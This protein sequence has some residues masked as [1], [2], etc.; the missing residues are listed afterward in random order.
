[1]PTD[2]P[3]RR[4]RYLGLFPATWN[5]IREKKSRQSEENNRESERPLNG[6]VIHLAMVPLAV[7]FLST[8]MRGDTIS[9]ESL[10]RTLL[11]GAE[12]LAEAELGLSQGMIGGI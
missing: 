3:L 4:H 6:T 1:M 7:L 5:P 2:L 9:V 12:A 10:F 11:L 8:L